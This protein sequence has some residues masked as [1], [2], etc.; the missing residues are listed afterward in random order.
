MNNVIFPDVLHVVGI[1]IVAS[2]PVIAIANNA[3]LLINVKDVRMD[4]T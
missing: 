2:R 1:E 4:I 3:I